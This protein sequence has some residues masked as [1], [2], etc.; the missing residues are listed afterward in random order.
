VL[1]LE[2]SAHDLGEEHAVQEPGVTQA[3]GLFFGIH[4]WRVDLDYQRIQRSRR[5]G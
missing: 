2:F 5:I 1:R 4:A 3:D